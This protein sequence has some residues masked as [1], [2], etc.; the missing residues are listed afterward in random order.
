MELNWKIKVY[1]DEHGKLVN[2]EFN[3]FQHYAGDCQKIMEKEGS[4]WHCLAFSC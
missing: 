4:I 3:V 2:I 1:L